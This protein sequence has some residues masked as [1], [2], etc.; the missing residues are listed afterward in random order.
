M[1]TKTVHDPLHGS[2]KLDGVFLELADRHELQRLR[3]VRQLG[4]GNYVFPGANHT[5][6]E[7]SLGVYHLSG[8]MASALSLPKEESDAVRAA[9]MLHDICHAPFSHTLDEIIKSR[10][11]S[12]HMESARML[13]EGKI[14]TYQDKDE[15]LL[16]GTKPISEILEAAGISAE[17]VCDLIAFP[18]APRSG[19]DSFSQDS[20]QSFFTSGDYLHQIIHGPVDSDQMDYLLRDAHYTGVTHGSIDVERLLSTIRVFNDRLVVEKRGMTAA[21]G[22]MVSRSLM[23]TSVYYHETVRVAEM[24]MIKAVEAPIWISEKY[25]SGPIRSWYRWWRARADVRNA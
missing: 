6:F 9:G 1:P 8:K 23:Y 7:H 20:G 12:D 14:K 10:L 2:I 3:Y 4:F 25:I 21:E 17:K 19:L 22:L 18:E 5:R 24:M 16:V 11:G 15:E 13:I